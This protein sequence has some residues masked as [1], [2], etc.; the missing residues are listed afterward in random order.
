LRMTAAA[1]CPPRLGLC[2]L[3]GG[4][5]IALLLQLGDLPPVAAF[6]A[7]TLLIWGLIRQWQQRSLLPQTLRHGLTAIAL[8][9]ALLVGL[10]Q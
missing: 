4:Y 9:L 8:I 2:L 10:P 6:V 5:L 1:W 3:S 7:I